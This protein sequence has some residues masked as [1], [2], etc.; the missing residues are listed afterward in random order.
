MAEKRARVRTIRELAPSVLLCDFEM[1]DPRA[2]AFRPG[3]FISIRMSPD[4]RVRRSYTIASFPER[5]DRFELVVKLVPSGMGSEFF[6]ALRPGDEIGF[7]G[8]MGF[9]V[10]D[11][12]HPGDVVFVATG[13]GIAAALPMIHEILG[14][15]P[16]VEGG[17]VLLYWGLRRAEDVFF[18]DRLDAEVSRSPRFAYHV[19]LSRPEPGWTGTEGRVGA[20][21]LAALPRLDRPVFYLVGNGDMIRDLRQALVDRGVDR[22]R[23]IHVEV[24][25]PAAEP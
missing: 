14:R 15:P 11:P 4:G 16:E 6:R 19:C 21:V 1:I 23:Q 25:Y 2:M 24:F 3:Q 8:P 20:H 13:S 9:F 10:P 12:A 5:A 7:T 18:R 17:R 22:K